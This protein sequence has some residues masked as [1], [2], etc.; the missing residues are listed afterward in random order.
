MPSLSDAGIPRIKR[1]DG[2]WENF[3]EMVGRGHPVAKRI[4]NLLA[5]PVRQELERNP[6]Y[7]KAPA[8]DALVRNLNIL[9]RRRD[10]FDPMAWQGVSIPDEARTL[11]AQGVSN[12]PTSELVRL[13]SLLLTAAFPEIRTPEK[14]NRNLLGYASAVIKRLLPQIWE[15]ASGRSVDRHAVQVSNELRPDL[16]AVRNQ[17]ASGTIPENWEDKSTAERIYLHQKQRLATRY[18]PALTWWNEQIRALGGN[19]TVRDANSLRGAKELFEQHP[20][21]V[22]GTLWKNPD[23]PYYLPQSAVKL[24]GIVSIQRML[25]SPGAKPRR[26]VP[27]DEYRAQTPAQSPPAGEMDVMRLLAGGHQSRTYRYVLD[28]LYHA[29]S[30]EHR[31]GTFLAS[32]PTSNPT[33]DQVDQFL[34]TLPQEF[35][36]DLD[37][38]GGWELMVRHV[39][40][41]VVEALKSPAMRTEVMMALRMQPQTLS[42]AVGAIRSR[43]FVRSVAISD[44]LYKASSSMPA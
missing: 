27:F 23:S 43:A 30:I 41:A 38:A 3:I 17:E 18:G 36:E 32:L 37:T 25:N 39:D 21:K 16:E 34:A 5:P 1:A 15:M 35:A 33:A 6:H 9:L 11:M 2:V 29:Q 31:V 42:S 13:N 10:F 26:I 14:P 44:S 12:L 8:A 20:D 19:Y 4:W 40:Q 24:F 28:R 7:L 22:P